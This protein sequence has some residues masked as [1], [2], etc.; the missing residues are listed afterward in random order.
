MNRRRWAFTLIELVVV[1][2]VIAILIG[3]LLPAVQKVRQ[4]AIRSKMSGSSPYGAAAEMAAQNVANRDEGKLSGTRPLARV[5]SFAAQ[6]ELMP[7]LS[8]GNATAESIYEAKFKAKLTAAK[9]PGAEVDCELQLPLPPQTIS[10]AD[11]NIIV[12]GKPSDVVAPRDGKLIWRGPLTGD[13]VAM[14][15]EYSAV[16]KGIYELAIP[17][18]G[19][20]DE[21]SIDLKTT[22]SDIS[23]LDLSLQPT[24]LENNF[25]STRYVWDYKRLLF[26]QPVRLDVLGIAPIDRLGELTW[27]GPLSVIAFG[28]IVGIILHTL[29][30]NPIDRWMLLLIIGTFAG[31]YPL[32]YFAQ[33]YVSLTSAIVASASLAVLIIGIRSMTLV[34]FRLGFMGVLLPAMTILALALTATIYPKSQ[35]VLLTVGAIGFF[36]VAMVFMPKISW[37]SLGALNAPVSAPEPPA[38]ETT[39]P[40]VESPKLD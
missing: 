10:L 36:V 17:P 9:P 3:L 4:T 32:M 39:P 19:I 38:K 1:I 20:L 11:L 27:I 25:G 13:N 18:G 21:F 6:V 28:L 30:K 16:G 15:I 37:D 12:D 23:L 40:T 5:K 26:G 34:G 22:G 33:E 31:C 14:T 2:A 29:P 35:G 8:I 7:K 24:S